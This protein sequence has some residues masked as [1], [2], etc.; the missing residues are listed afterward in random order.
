MRC[1]DENADHVLAATE[2]PESL[3]AVLMQADTDGDAGINAAEMRAFL[4][5]ARPEGPKE[6]N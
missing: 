4:V 5:P 3:R 6:G 1:F 2:I